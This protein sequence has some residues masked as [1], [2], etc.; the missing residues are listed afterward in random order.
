MDAEN[1][2]SI[3]C[4]LVKDILST[5]ENLY[6]LSNNEREAIKIQ[7]EF[8]RIYQLNDLNALQHFHDQ[9]DI[10]SEDNQTPSIN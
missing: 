6:R 7:D 5:I 2:N 1:N 3:Q 10:L 9:L 4:L 8:Y